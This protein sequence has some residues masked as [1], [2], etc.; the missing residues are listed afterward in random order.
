[1]LSPVVYNDAHAD[2]IPCLHSP[3]SLP[4]VGTLINEA[5][6]KDWKKEDI[7]NSPSQNDST[8]DTQRLDGGWKAWSVVLASVLIQTFAFAPTEFIFGVFEQE[9]LLVFT[10]E[11][12][13]SIALIGTIGTATTYLLGMFSGA[14]AD[15][16][17][18]RRTASVGTMIMTIALLLASFS[19][20]LWHLYLTQGILF[21]AGASL[22]YFAAIAAPT[23]WFIKKR[24]MAI[25]IGASGAGLGG[26]YLAPL[27]QY[28]TE[29]IGIQWT[30]RFL[31]LYSLIV[32]GV[33]SVL[34]FT[35]DE[36]AR[37]EHAMDVD[38]EGV[39]RTTS[40]V[41]TESQQHAPKW[42]GVSQLPEYSKE[43]G[44]IMLVSFQLLLSMAY[45]T[46]IYFME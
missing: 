9:Y 37:P 8:T 46:P 35:R 38:D 32:C 31:G 40:T 13:S 18:Y 7:Y 20:Q 14:F 22:V 24:G 17:G 11:S 26:F 5:D 36:L 42:W 39:A 44:F 30:L 34:M 25:G 19:T 21:G 41:A 28:L 4:S 29:K 1:M 45:L 6:N 12:S 16:W 33:A 10:E 27:T 3:N 43:T 2:V 15:R 23:H